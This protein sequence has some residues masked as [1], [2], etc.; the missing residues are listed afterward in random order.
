MARRKDPLE[1][2]RQKRD[3]TVTPEPAPERA[4]PA[5]AGA[6]RFM[7]HKHDATRLHYDLRLEMGGVLASWAIPKGPSYDPAQKR[8]AVETEDH[9]LAYGDFEGRIPDGE[10]GA[11]DSIIW[12]RGTYDS[13]PPGEAEAQRRK[14]HL[15]L[16]FN[17]QKLKGGWHLVRTR[18]QGGKAQ[19]LLFKAK[20][21]TERPDYD[22]VAER[23]ESVASGRRVTRGPERQRQLRGVHPDPDRLLA[24]V[25]PPMLA[26]LSKGTPAPASR[27][28]YEVKYDGYRAL[29]AISGG[30]VSVRS[31]N[32]LD[33][34]TRFP[35]VLPALS[36]MVVGEAVLDGELVALDAKGVSRFQKLADPEAEHRY[37]VFDLLW[38]DGEDLRSRPLEE[39]RELLE[40]VMANTRP[41]LELAQRVRG[42]EESALAEAKRRGWEGLLAKLRGSPYTGTRSADWLKLKVLGTDELVIAGWTPIS[43]GA[44]EIG[45]LLVAARRGSAFVYAGKVGTGFDRTMRRRLL[46][47]LKKDEVPRPA[48]ED[49]PRMRDAHWVKPRHVAELQFTEWTRDGRLRHP[50]F[51]GL[52]EDKGPLEIGQDEPGAARPAKASRGSGAAASGRRAAGR[53]VSAARARTTSGRRGSTQGK[54]ASPKRRGASTPS[55]KGGGPDGA[56]PDGAPATGFFGTSPAEGFG[57]WHSNRGD[58]DESSVTASPPPSSQVTASEPPPAQVPITHPEKVLFPLSKITKADVRAYD[59]AVAPALIAALRGRPLSMQQWPQG[60]GKPGIFRQGATSAPPWIPRVTVQHVDHPLEHIVVDR[61]ETVSWLANQSALTLHMTSSRAATVDEPDWVAFDFDPAEA[62]WAQIAPLAKALKGLLD[63]LKLTSVPKTSGKR[64][65]HVFVPLGPGHTHAQTLGFAEAVAGALAARFPDLATTER[66]LNRR[67]G[68]LYLDAHQ[69][70]RLKTMVAPYSIRPVEG[71]PVSTPLEWDEV[72]AR[73][74]P[75]KFNIHTVPRRLRE[76]G[77]LFAPALAGKQ[78]L[79]EFRA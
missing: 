55:S 7:V 71:A 52:R 65:L 48:I 69:N 4:A 34:G 72:S 41:P 59:D 42:D 15:H 38:L 54:S 35:W 6:L 37:V 18:P 5:P 32:D 12:D 8:L 30:K 75:G 47:L 76:R 74:E 19:W 1:T 53:S 31:R 44:A 21:G 2:Y 46:T 26:V 23:P 67:R 39:R 62:G 78:R 58:G 60:I 66:A 57:T 28:V 25:W 61:P 13:E 49:A 63:E 50:S 16:V 40:S 51:Q 77:D 56:D 24:R 9:P 79:P 33:F 11:G 43:N 17:G 20:D 36:Q 45:A 70:G 3:F 22:V 27:Y 10:Y 73:L 64:G 68:R 29:A 14:G